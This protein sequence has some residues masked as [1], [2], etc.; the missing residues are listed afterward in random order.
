[1]QMEEVVVYFK[2]P[3]SNLPGQIDEKYH[4]KCSP[5]HYYILL[6]VILLNLFFSIIII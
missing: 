3:S 6:C 2:T 1:M 4:I 5:K